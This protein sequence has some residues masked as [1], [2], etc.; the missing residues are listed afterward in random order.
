MNAPTPASAQA[1]Q[2]AAPAKTVGNQ[3][4]APTGGGAQRKPT[5]AK[6]ASAFSFVP[7]T[8]E[9]KPQYLKMLIYGGPGMGKTTLCGSASNVDSASD[10]LLITA[11]G[12]DIVFLDND[13]IER[14]ERIDMMKV[15]NI[16]QLQKVYEWLQR[17]TIFREAGDTERMQKLQNIA[18][19]GTAEPPE[20]L[21]NEHPEFHRLR[22]YRTVIID[23]LTDVEALNMNS[24][25]GINEESGFIVGEDLT[26][27]GYSEF[28]KNYNTIQQLVRAFRNLPLHVL[29]ICGQK[30]QKDELQR[31]H[32][33]P[34][35]TG[36][37]ATQV[38]SF[39]DIVGWMV[40]GADP[41]DASKEM[42]K[43][44]VQPMNQV[45]FDAKCRIAS[46]KKPSFDDPLFEDIL[47]AC[48]Y[49]TR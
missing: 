42:H 20:E 8:S 25:L 45:K 32:Y 39:V 9:K 27:P 7:V 38:Q 48:G 13:R 19:F 21:W 24:V 3:G 14:P 35:M 41:K 44:Y 29:L 43:L 5:E 37:L 34:W 28:R 16:Q 6:S 2:A 36:Q 46:Y 12:G 26:P 17:H 23:S 1:A 18:F 22:T 11:E 49:P 31:F 40:K 47:K 30:W 10:V 4:P 15:S 33:G